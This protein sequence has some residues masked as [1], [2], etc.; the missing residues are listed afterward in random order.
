MLQMMHPEN[1]TS[2]LSADSPIT[3]NGT[4]LWEVSADV[5]VINVV[6]YLNLLPGT[7]PED[8]INFKLVFDLFKYPT[9]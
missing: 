9:K 5:E 2:P 1:F 4:K 7:I 6:D 3:I 8:L